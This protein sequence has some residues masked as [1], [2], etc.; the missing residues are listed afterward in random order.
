[1]TP[2]MSRGIASTTFKDKGLPSIEHFYPDIDWTLYASI[3]YSQRSAVI[4]A[5]EEPLQPVV[6]KRR[7]K[8]QNPNLRMSANN[9][10][11]I[12]RFFLSKGLVQQVWIRAQAHPRYQLTGLGRVF[13]DLLQRAS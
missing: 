11:D 7:A 3:C 1:M 10:R 8:F 13:R 6:N 2:Q 5:L 12:I 9:V 4:K